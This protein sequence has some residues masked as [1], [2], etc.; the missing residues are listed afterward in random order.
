MGSTRM[1]WWRKSN[2]VAGDKSEQKRGEEEKENMRKTEQ[3]QKL[4]LH[5]STEQNHK[6]QRHAGGRKVRHNCWGRGTIM[7][8]E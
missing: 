6:Q 1:Q 3:N 2:M 4:E 7:L 5:A 8:R